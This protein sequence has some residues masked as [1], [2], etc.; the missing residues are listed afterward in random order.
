VARVSVLLPVRD[1]VST[2]PECLA[3]ICSQ[4][5]A[6]L[7]VVAVDDGSSDGS[8]ELLEAEARREP[9]LRVLRTS[10]RGLVPALALA[11]REARAPILARM[12]AD[13]VADP[14]RLRLQ[15]E[16]F[17]ARPGDRAVLGT[18]VRLLQDARQPA[19]G[20]RAYVAWSNRLTEHAAIVRDLWVESPLVHPSVA[21]PASLLAELGG[22]RD[23]DGPED[24]DLWLRA[25]AGGALFAKLDEPLLA[26]RDSPSRLTRRSPRYAPGRFLHVKLLG[27]EA[28]PLRGRDGVVVWGAGPIGKAWARALRERGHRVRAFVEVD[29]RKLGQR[30]GGAPVVALDA[31]PGEGAWLHLAAVGQ[32][33]ARERIRQEAAR[34]GLRD[35]QDLIAVA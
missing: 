1:A 23:L 21:L 34:L 26:W 13:D 19:A 12:D 3:S 17:A 9:R 30:I 4:D 25:H 7:E 5:M 33:G 11:A 35:G 20:M 18:R 31:L 8:G 15:L 14:R 16:W 24:Y 2:L 27:L 10:P 6:E 22:Y 28:G 29:P 32:P